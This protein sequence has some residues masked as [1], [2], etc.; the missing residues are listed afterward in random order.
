MFGNTSDCPGLKKGI[1]ALKLRKW[2]ESLKRQSS[3]HEN[4][5]KKLILDF[6][7]WNLEFHNLSHITLTSP[8]SLGLKFRP[9]PRPPTACVFDGLIQDFCGSVHLHYKYADQPR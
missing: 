7:S 1:E 3:A 8:Q 4:W 2:Q 6:L 9:T 5:Q